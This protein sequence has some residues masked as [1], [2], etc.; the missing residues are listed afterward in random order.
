[1]SPFSKR[2]VSGT[3]E[4]SAGPVFPLDGGNEKCLRNRFDDGKWLT[5]LHLAGINPPKGAV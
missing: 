5:Y 3:A 2:I 1:M 4:V